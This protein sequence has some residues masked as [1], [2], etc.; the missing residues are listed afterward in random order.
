MIYYYFLFSS[1]Q[2]DKLIL[3][4]KKKKK[5][6]HQTFTTIQQQDTMFSSIT[7]RLEL[8]QNYLQS[9]KK[10]ITKY[11]GRRKKVQLTERS[12]HAIGRT[13]LGMPDQ[14][15]FRNSSIKKEVFCEN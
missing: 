13:R 5:T 7:D 2:F 12:F 4:L 15:N 1:F 10:L 11:Q 6:Q 3:Q 14:L 8:K 9:L